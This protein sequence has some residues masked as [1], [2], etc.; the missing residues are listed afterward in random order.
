MPSVSAT[1]RRTAGSGGQQAGLPQAAL[2]SLALE[3]GVPLEQVERV[4]RKEASTLEATAR[5][6]HFVPVLVASHVRNA[7]RRQQRGR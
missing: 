6:K 7:L 2:E 1:A 3:L 4:Y 5:I